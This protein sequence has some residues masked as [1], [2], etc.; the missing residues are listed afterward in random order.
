MAAP[1]SPA[2][3]WTSF[4]PAA[5]TFDRQFLFPAA[6][7]DK[8]RFLFVSSDLQVRALLL[9]PVR[10]HL[11]KEQPLLQKLQPSTVID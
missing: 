2:G 6:N 9:L 3:N 1:S 11:G 8:L 5:F 7:S 4:L 10:Q